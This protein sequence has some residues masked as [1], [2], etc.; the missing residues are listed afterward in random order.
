MAAKG[1]TLKTGT[2]TA[3]G[4]G[5]AVVTP[6]DAKGWVG[7]LK[8]TSVTGTNPTLAVKIQHS[9]DATN[10]VDLVTF[11]QA[12]TTTVEHKFPTA[13]A[14]NLIPILPN[15]RASYTVGGTASPTFVGVEI[16]LFVDR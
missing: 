2:I 7:Y 4:A 8:V 11:T 15:L 12:T 13:A 9:A 14:D 1:V 3:T 10:W 16:K 5:S 6:R